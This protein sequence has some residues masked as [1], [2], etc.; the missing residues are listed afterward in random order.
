MEC[1][2]CHHKCEKIFQCR[3]C[4]AQFCGRCKADGI[5]DELLGSQFVMGPRCPHC[6]SGYGDLLTSEREIESSDSGSEANKDD[7]DTR[8]NS[9]EGSPSHSTDSYSS[10]GDS[11]SYEGSSSDSTDSYS[12]SDD[13]SS[14]DIGDFFKGVIGVVIIIFVI[15]EIGRAHV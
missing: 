15:L 14:S 6:S 8:S 13:S 9:Y 2:S 3:D 5:T 11:S 7:H 10:S 12:S 4:H 1:P